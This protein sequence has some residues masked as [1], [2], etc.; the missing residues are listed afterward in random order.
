MYS[1]LVMQYFLQPRFVYPGDAAPALCVG[2]AESGLLL[3]WFV[4]KADKKANKQVR[5][6]V[7]GN[8][9]AVAVAEC[10]CAHWQDT[11]TLPTVAGV[12]QHLQLDRRTRWIVTTACDSWQRL[13]VQRRSCS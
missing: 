2:A 12:M 1:D 9:V 5:Y 7:Y 13:P 11:K 3:C 4:D 10:C 8:P 6:R